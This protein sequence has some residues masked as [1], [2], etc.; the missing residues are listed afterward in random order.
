MTDRS[1][2]L[3]LT[4]AAPNVFRNV[5]VARLIR[6]VSRKHISVADSLLIARSIRTAPVKFED[7]S[8]YWD[9]KF[10]S[11]KGLL[12][13]WLIAEFEEPYNEYLVFAKRQKAFYDMLKAGGDGDAAVAYCKAELAGEISHGVMG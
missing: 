8:R 2:T 4:P 10:A 5:D 11:D 6:N 7:D 12:P 9:F 13:T 1:V 3:S